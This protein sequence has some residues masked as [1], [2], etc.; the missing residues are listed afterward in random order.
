MTP[1]S[2]SDMEPL[3]P[4]SPGRLNTAQRE[5]FSSVVTEL[6]RLGFDRQSVLD[7]VPGWIERLEAGFS[8]SDGFFALHDE[9]RRWVYWTTVPGYW[10]GYL[11]EEYALRHF[12][13][14]RLPSSLLYAVA[15]ETV[16]SIDGAQATLELAY[17]DARLNHLPV[18]MVA[19]VVARLL[20]YH[21]FYLRWSQPHPDPAPMPILAHPY[22]NRTWRTLHTAFPSLPASIREATVAQLEA[23][24]AA[25]EQPGREYFLVV[26][27]RWLAVLL[28]RE[29]RTDEALDH[30]QSALYEAQNIPLE[31]LMSVSG[32][33]P[34]AVRLD[35]EIG[36]LHRL[37]AELFAKHFHLVEAEDEHALALAHEELATPY[38]EYWRALSGKCL[39]RVRLE[40]WVLQGQ[41]MDLFEAALDAYRT[42]RE[43]LD[44]ALRGTDSPVAR[45]A[46]VQLLRGFSHYLIDLADAPS[47]LDKQLPGSHLKEAIAEIESQN[48]RAAG[49]ALTEL[50]AAGSAAPEM[51]SLRATFHRHLT[52]V[53]ESF[54]EYLDA[55][56][57]ERE[58]RRL[59][60]STR[61]RANVIALQSLT[62]SSSIAADLLLRMHVPG[63]SV[64]VF[65]VD[66]FQGR[67]IVL[68]LDEAHSPT[69]V[70]FF[71]G[72]RQLRELYSGFREDLARYGASPLGR[73]P[74]V[75]TLLARTTELLG[76]GLGALIERVDGRHVKLLTQGP[77]SLLPL[78]AVPT[79]AGRLID[80]CDVSYCPS[81]A[82][83]S[84]GGLVKGVAKQL[85]LGAP[86]PDI[87]ASTTTILHNS[88]DT[89]YLGCAIGSARAS[90]NVVVLHDPDEPT[91]FQAIS[92]PSVRDLIFACH[93]VYRPDDPAN[94]HLKIA[95]ELTLAEL[96]EHADLT[97][98]RSVTLAACSSGRSR[99]EIASESVGLVNVFLGAGAQTVVGTLWDVDQ[100][101]TAL[102]LENYLEGLVHDL[103]P[104]AALNAAQRELARTP[105]ESVRS[106]LQQHFPDRP[107]L[108]AVRLSEFPYAAPVH[109]AGFVAS[110]AL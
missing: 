89:T 56:P 105:A 76:D 71:L 23:V 6:Y 26:A 100:L 50:L 17:H 52:T 69:H 96:F 5:L 7:A 29:G 12:L 79:S 97:N 31:W 1:S 43:A 21:R 15:Q 28:D 47:L 8:G 59:Y 41:G 88:A 44:A 37:R 98:C 55:I 51:Q 92:D 58:L 27:R 60:R 54:Q 103:T 4:G 110:G 20:D 68:D 14:G 48:P 104:T 95:G 49:D 72:E 33:L 64:A 73:G 36:H 70:Q 66:D 10:L 74:A 46:M 22:H 39:G 101:A 67:I 18:E 83:L 91:A 106:W 30:L 84:A 38:C 34:D 63:T 102:L 109:W 16:G 86:G 75:D 61:R 35:S 87:A 77:L 81:V 2:A 45:A 9:V 3:R 32:S 80:H 78:H 53:P 19:P 25:C 11:L 85:S 94:S 93:G 90:G 42:G 65:H 108:Q 57:Q 62:Q 99:A 13:I 82:L 40:R 107:R 24:V